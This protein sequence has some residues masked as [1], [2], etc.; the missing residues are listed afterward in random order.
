MSDANAWV[1]GPCPCPDCKNKR[2]SAEAV[3]KHG[4]LQAEMQAISDRT[5]KLNRER[6]EA[7]MNA[8]SAQQQLHAG[9]GSI[10]VRAL[11]RLESARAVVGAAET[12]RH[13]AS[14]EVLAAEDA[15][16]RARS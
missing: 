4:R 11:A 2:A 12:M 3:A 16:N 13:L 15:V 14:L 1:I 10:L 7:A 8:P 5:E 6:Y 9:D